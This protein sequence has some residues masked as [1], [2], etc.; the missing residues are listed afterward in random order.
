MNIISIRENEKQGNECEKGKQKSSFPGVS[1]SLFFFCHCLTIGA[2]RCCYKTSETAFPLIAQPTFDRSKSTTFSYK[3]FYR[4]RLPNFIH[5]RSNSFSASFSISADNPLF[6]AM[7][8]TLSLS[9]AVAHVVNFLTEKFTSTYPDN[10][11]IKLQSALKDNLTAHYAPYWDVQRPIKGSGRRSMTLSP[12]CLPPRPIWSA[13]VTADVQW[14]DWISL[15]GN[16]EFDLFVDP[17]C[18]AVR[19]QNMVYSVWSAELAPTAV[20]VFNPDQTM[21]IPGTVR[22]TRTFAQQPIGNDLEKYLSLFQ[23]LATR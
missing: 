7:D 14:F 22:P 10:T 3:L 21:F 9:T 5:S 11:L 16:R 17:G 1:K 12:L 8:S 15:L 4:P 20:P 13:C 6:N 18:I 19:C 23:V 2:C